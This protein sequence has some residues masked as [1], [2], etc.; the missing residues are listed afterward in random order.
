MT[1]VCVVSVCCLTASQV[2]PWTAQTLL[3]LA[4]EVA[5]T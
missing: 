3:Q 5:I 4:R 2:R 1:A